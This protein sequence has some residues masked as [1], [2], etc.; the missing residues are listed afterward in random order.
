MRSTVVLMHL[1]A[2]LFTAM[3]IG[4]TLYRFDDHELV[5]NFENIC[6]FGAFTAITKTIL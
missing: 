1:F 4:L 3:L 2:P 5:S 6:L